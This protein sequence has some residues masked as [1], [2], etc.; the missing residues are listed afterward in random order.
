M[1]FARIAIAFLLAGLAT[2]AAGGAAAAEPP[3]MTHNTITSMTHNSIQEM[4]HN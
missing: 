2:L 1:R 4:T 3:D